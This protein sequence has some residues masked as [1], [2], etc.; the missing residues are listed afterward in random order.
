MC[1]EYIMDQPKKLKIQQGF[2]QKVSEYHLTIEI[3]GNPE[4]LLLMINPTDL[5]CILGNT[6]LMLEIRNQRL[7]HWKLDMVDTP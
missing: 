3:S 7:A 6:K 2:I 1:G 5:Q 4:K